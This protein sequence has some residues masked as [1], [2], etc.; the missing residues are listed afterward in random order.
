V[1]EGADLATSI[2][3]DYLHAAGMTLARIKDGVYTYMHPD[4]LGSAS[5]GSNEDGSSAFTEYHS[6]FGE[7]LTG[8]AANDNQS[9]FTGHIR[10]KAIGLNYMQARY[11]DPNIGRFLSI[12]PMQFD[13][14]NNP[15]Y[16][17]R[18][19]YTFNDPVN[20][21]DPTGMV[22]EMKGSAADRKEFIDIAT[23][24]TGI[25]L[26]EKGGKLVGEGRG[27]LASNPATDSLFE[28]IDSSNTITVDAVR[29]DPNVLIDSF[30]TNKVDVGDIGG[31]QNSDAKLGAAVLTHVIAEKNHQAANGQGFGPAHQS[32]LAQ[33][34]AVMGAA[35]RTE[36]IDY[37]PGGAF[38]IQYRNSKGGIVS[39]HNLTFDKNGTP[40]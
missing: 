3:T 36:S 39:S 8:T 11:Y 1:E 12:D 19:S 38:G 26:S 13:G 5:A 30:A 18:Y 21:I 6:P 14:A 35:T 24:A 4:H 7:A 23:K 9:D 32:G 15:A 34:S 10:D 20:L 40:K 2:Q 29:D 27:V 25:Q 31:I 37:K 17:N 33:E 16:F 22:V 28:A